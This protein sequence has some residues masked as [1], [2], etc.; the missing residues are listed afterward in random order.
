LKKKI[1]DL[2]TEINSNKKQKEIV[3]TQINSLVQQRDTL[4]SQLNLK[5]EESKIK[6]NSNNKKLEDEIVTYFL[7]FLCSWF[8]LIG[9][10]DDMQSR[11]GNIT[12]SD[13]KF[14]FYVKKWCLMIGRK[15]PRC[16]LATGG[17]NRILK[18]IHHKN[19]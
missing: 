1:D 19:Q 3:N 17:G 10:L 16:I 4:Q 18:A 6:T 7:Y 12:H 8:I 14:V 11:N 15:K 9:F 5:I 2:K 13:A